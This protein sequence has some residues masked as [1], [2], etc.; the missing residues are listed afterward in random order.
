MVNA[1]EISYFNKMEISNK[2]L[3]NIYLVIIVSLIYTNF[4]FNKIY[5][6]LF[7]LLFNIVGKIFFLII[8]IIN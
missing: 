4:T 3:I 6:I 7:L 8:K 5:V 2:Y 1:Y